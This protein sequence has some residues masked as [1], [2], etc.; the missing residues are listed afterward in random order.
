MKLSPI[1]DNAIAM[2]RALRRFAEEM[3]NNGH[4][5]VY[6]DMRNLLHAINATGNASDVL[7]TLWNA[8]EDE[9]NPK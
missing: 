1:T 2:E 8:V 5:V 4:P 3:K 6:N 7:A 9:R